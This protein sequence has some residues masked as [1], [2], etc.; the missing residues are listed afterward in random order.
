MNTISKAGLLVRS[1]VW[2]VTVQL[3]PRAAAATA[4]AACL[5]LFA[6]TIEDNMVSLVFTYIQNNILTHEWRTKEAGEMAL[7]SILEGPSKESLRKWIDI[8]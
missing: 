6:Q 4:A 5:S 7:A 1:S 3:I 8:L 2:A